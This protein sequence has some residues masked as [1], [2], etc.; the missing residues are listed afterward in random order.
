[1]VVRG[2][3]FCWADAIQCPHSHDPLQP[4]LGKAGKEKKGRK[5]RAALACR[6]LLGPATNEQGLA[7]GLLLPLPRPCPRQVLLPPVP[8]PHTPVQVAPQDRPR[9]PQAA[10]FP[11]SSPA[12]AAATKVPYCCSC[13]RST[14]SRP[15]P[16]DSAS[17]SLHHPIPSSPNRTAERGHIRIHMY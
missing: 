10:A 17:S 16:K 11:F 6:S 1:M 12:Y 8:H 9:A 5:K 15:S 7:A 2:L 13:C 4:A 3:P 14:N